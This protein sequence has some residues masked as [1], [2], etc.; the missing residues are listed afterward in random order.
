MLFLGYSSWHRTAFRLE[1]CRILLSIK[2]NCNSFAHCHLFCQIIPTHC[3][4]Y[5]ANETWTLS[6]TKTI[7][8]PLQQIHKTS[9]T[10]NMH[11]H[12]FSTPET[13][14][15]SH[16]R[17]YLRYILYRTLLHTSIYVANCIWCWNRMINGAL[18]NFAYKS[19]ST[20]GGRGRTSVRASR[21]PD[22]C[23]AVW[24]K[25]YLS[26]WTIQYP[27]R[28]LAVQLSV[29]VTATATFI[30]RWSIYVYMGNACLLAS[31]TLEWETHE[32]TVTSITRRR[33]TTAFSPSDLRE[34]PMLYS[35]IINALMNTLDLLGKICAG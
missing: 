21:R 16:I 2:W 14:R 7:L 5:N 11:S 31:C 1:F 3:K 6:S 15:Q 17:M 18:M 23:S 4:S 10:K 33:M 32:N 34:A 25:C 12:T 8:P 29:S 19:P 24:C 13:R 26:V 30:G 28:A 20:A 27:T 35:L 9:Y 22:G